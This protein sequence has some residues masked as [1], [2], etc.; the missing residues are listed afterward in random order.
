MKTETESRQWI[1]TREILPCGVR[2]SVKRWTWTKRTG[3][4]VEYKNS[5][6][7]DGKAD[8]TLPELLS[9]IR[10]GREFAAEI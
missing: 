9:A 1:P 3:L 7:L 4:L 5:P 8:Y 2:S 6:W 10:D